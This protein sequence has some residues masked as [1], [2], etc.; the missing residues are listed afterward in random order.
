M[1][2]WKSSHVLFV[3]SLRLG[4]R[5]ALHTIRQCCARWILLTLDG[6]KQDQMEITHELLAS[7]SSCSRPTMTEARGV[8]EKSGCITIRRGTIQIIDRR[9][10]ESSTCE[11][12]GLVDGVFQDFRQKS[13]SI[14]VQ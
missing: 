5:N 9:K 8:I 13:V 2:C 7:L 10:L 3:G 14:V 12:Y 4:A 1:S 6:T 11:C